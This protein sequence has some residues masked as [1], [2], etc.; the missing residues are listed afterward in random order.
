MDSNGTIIPNVKGKD[1]NGVVKRTMSFVKRDVKPEFWMTY[2]YKKNSDTNWSESGIWNGADIPGGREFHSIV[3]PLTETFIESTLGPEELS[4]K[5]VHLEFIHKPDDTGLDLFTF[6][7][8][9][10]FY[11]LALKIPD[12]SYSMLSCSVEE[13]IP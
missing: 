5:K 9:I 12:N 4:K 7:P 8:Q 2:L 3:D 11:G 1:S 6:C 10:V 13:F